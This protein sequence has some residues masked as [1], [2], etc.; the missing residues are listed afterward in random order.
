MLVPSLFAAAANDA[1]GNAFLGF[2]ILGGI[3][4]FCVWL[5]S[6]PKSYTINSRTTGTIRRN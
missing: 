4:W 5:G 3:I 6:K 2:M 1:D